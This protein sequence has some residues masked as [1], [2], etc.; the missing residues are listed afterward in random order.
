MIDTSAGMRALALS[1]CV[2]VLLV[3]IAPIALLLVRELVTTFFI[4]QHRED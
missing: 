2:P 1:A 3:L 4:D